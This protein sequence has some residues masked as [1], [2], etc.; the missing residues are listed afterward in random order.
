VEHRALIGPFAHVPP[1]ALQQEEAAAQ[2]SESGSVRWSKCF[3]AS[4]PN[5][6]PMRAWPS[7]LSAK[8]SISSHRASGQRRRE[9]ELRAGDHRISR[10]R[11][12]ARAEWV[13]A[14]IDT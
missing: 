3:F 4:S 2:S 1:T 7:K 8:R 12:I 10:L 14:P 13:N 5:R 11:S 6:W 9:R